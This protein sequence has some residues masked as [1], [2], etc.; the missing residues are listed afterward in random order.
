MLVL[1][2]VPLWHGTCL[3]RHNAE[4]EILGLQHLLIQ[5]LRDFFNVHN[6][7]LFLSDYEYSDN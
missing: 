7:V 1:G 3:W 5:T 2:L 6:F 4:L